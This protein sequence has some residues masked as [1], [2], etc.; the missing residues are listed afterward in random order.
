MQW[1]LTPPAQVNKEQ[2]VFLVLGYAEK[3]AVAA[4][5]AVGIALAAFFIF[6]PT[7]EVSLAGSAEGNS[8]TALLWLTQLYPIVPA[9]IKFIALPFIWNY[10]LTEERQRRIRELID[11]RGVVLHR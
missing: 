11:R 6:D 10:P 1:N 3:G 9:G 2:A 8:D 5:G 7:A 4:D